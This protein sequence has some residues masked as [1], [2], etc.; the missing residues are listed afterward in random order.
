MLKLRPSPAVCL[1]V[2]PH[3]LYQNRPVG[4]RVFDAETPLQIGNV[5]GHG[6]YC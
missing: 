3:S 2:L 5:G 4:K 1:I 6:Q